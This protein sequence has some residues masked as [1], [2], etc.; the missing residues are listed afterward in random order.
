MKRVTLHERMTALRRICIVTVEKGTPRTEI[1]RALYGV[2]AFRADCGKMCIAIND[3]IDPNNADAVFWAM[4]YRCN[5]VED[6]QVVPLREAGHAP[7]T[8]GLSEMESALLVDATLKYPMPPVALPKKEFMENAKALW[9]RLGLP[10]KML[11]EIHYNSKQMNSFRGRLFS[12]VV[13]TIKDIGLWGPR[14]RKAFAEMG[15]MDYAE[16]NVVEQ[17]DN[18]GKVAEDFDRKMFVDKAI[19][20]E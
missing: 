19:A 5:P 15:V 6:T 12:R 9:E 17:L 16:I 10:Q 7:R 2:A 13:P 18:D 3:D 1:W 8:E 14:V 11:D 20:A 4:S